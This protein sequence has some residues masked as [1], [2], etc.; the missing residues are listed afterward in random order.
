MNLNQKHLKY[1]DLFITGEIPAGATKK[2]LYL[3]V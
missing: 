3:T 2:L 1:P